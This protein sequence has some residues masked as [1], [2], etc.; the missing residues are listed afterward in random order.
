[1]QDHHLSKVRR[2]NIEDDV[3][4]QQ[5]TS[6]YIQPDVWH[7]LSP[8]QQKAIMQARQQN[9]SNAPTNNPNAR[10][11]KGNGGKDSKK[12]R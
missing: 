7:A 5:S 10:N 11:E 12:A 4:E 8:E 1:V 2:L 9:P 6:T 3:S